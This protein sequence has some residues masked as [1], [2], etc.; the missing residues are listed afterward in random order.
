MHVRVKGQL[1]SCSGDH[2][3]YHQFNPSSDD[4]KFCS[5]SYSP[6]STPHI[7]SVT[8]TT[9][10]SGE[11]VTIMGSGFTEDP[12]LILVLFG[13]IPCEVMSASSDEVTC[14]LEKGTAGQKQIFL[15]VIECW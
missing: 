7:H 15:Q 12:G 13:D 5:F 2:T 6:P 3:L 10:G 9:A 4:V 14:V 11:T 8:P 1:A